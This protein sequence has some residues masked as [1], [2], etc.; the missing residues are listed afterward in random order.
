MNVDL[1]RWLAA[2]AVPGRPDEFESKQLLS[3]YGIATPAGARIGPHDPPPPPAESTRVVPESTRVV[4]AESTR[5]VKV[6]SPDLAH[7]TEA[8]AVA[9]GVAAGELESTVSAFRARFPGAS[10]LVE[11]EIRGVGAELIVGGLV[12]ATFGQAVMV[13]S[14]GILTELLEDVAFR[15]APCG[16]AEARR[17]LDELHVAPLFHGFRGLDLDADGLADVIHRVSEIVCALGDRFVALD[18]NPLV[19]SDGRWVALDAR[20]ELGVAAGGAKINPGRGVA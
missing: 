4:P 9:L 17:M 13:G 11:E 19:F 6:C 10:L 20:I 2:L 18:V 14:G 8:R 12:D 1:P 16:V 5:V 3:G 15:L 7:K